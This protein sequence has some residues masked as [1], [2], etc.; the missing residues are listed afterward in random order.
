MS[1]C[2]TLC[3]LYDGGCC[4]HDRVH[5]HVIIF[6]AKVHVVVNCYNLPICQFYI[7]L[8]DILLSIM[9]TCV[10]SIVVPSLQWFISIN[11]DKNCGECIKL[12]KWAT[13]C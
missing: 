4:I 3:A 10:R 11:F 1:K 5:I 7:F 9:S 2:C 13:C 12:V 8:C 6:V